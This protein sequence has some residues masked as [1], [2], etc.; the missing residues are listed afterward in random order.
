[1]SFGGIVLAELRKTLSLPV[2]WAGVA[3]MVLLSAA[4]TAYNASSVR[5]ALAAGRPGD[6]AFGSA[7]ETAFAAVP[8]GTVGAAVI[9][10]IAIGSEYTANSTDAGGGRQV[11]ATLAAVPK[12]MALLAAKVVTVALVVAASAA[13]TLLSTVGLAD[14]VIGAHATSS[15]PG[16]LALTRSLGTALYWILTALIG[17]AITVLTRNGVVPL[18]ILIINN[19]LVSFSLLLTSLTPL[20]HWLPD[21][22]GRR[23]F[24]IDT[25]EGGLAA[26]PG[27]FVMAGWTVLLLVVA[28]IAFT[29]RDA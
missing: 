7:F 4:L 18:A 29:R 2:A 17:F 5:D 1:M 26:V 27:A 10:V 6:T 15:V 19:S 12:R 14:V 24:G 3:V 16:D 13:V 9:G 25:I 11:S 23:L 20:A 21:M 8:L 28:A 22:A